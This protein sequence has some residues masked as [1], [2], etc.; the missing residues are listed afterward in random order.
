MSAKELP[1]PHAIPNVELDVFPQA[2]NWRAYFRVLMFLRDC[3]IRLAAVV[4][5]PLLNVFHIII[6][7]FLSELLM[8]S[9]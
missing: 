1:S 4:L 6:F 7:V 2:K 9:S 5:L 3:S 8:L